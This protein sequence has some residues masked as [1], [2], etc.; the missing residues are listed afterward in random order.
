MKFDLSGYPKASNWSISLFGRIITIADV[1]DAITSPRVYR[2][3]SLSPDRALGY[4]IGK[5]GKDFDPILLKVF[6]NIL[7][8]YPPGTLVELDSDEIGL[9]VDTP[10]ENHASGLPRVL[11]LLPDGN[12]GYIKGETI[13]LAEQSSE[14]G[15]HQRN[16]V[17]TVHPATYNIQPAQYFF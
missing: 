2:K 16:I 6:I 8:F 5:T 10:R 15:A 3:S 14:T 1:F 17:N 12:N 4:M 7:G 9:V 11:L 13:N